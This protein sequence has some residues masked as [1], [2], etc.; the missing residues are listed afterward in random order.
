MLDGHAIEDT[1]VQRIVHGRGAC[2]PA[3]G[4]LVHHGA[5]G[6]LGDG[7]GKHGAGTGDDADGDAA[8][9]LERRGHLSQRSAIDEILEPQR[10]HPQS[11]YFEPGQRVGRGSTHGAVRA[12]VSVP[13][14]IRLAR[15]S[16][17]GVVT[18]SCRAALLTS[19]SP[20]IDSFL[21]S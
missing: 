5:D 2:L 1:K 3:A 12:S 4:M 11:L 16:L 18:P 13:T 20:S 7:M 15:R 6:R 10:P 17:T 9:P 14:P 21:E 19:S 8:K